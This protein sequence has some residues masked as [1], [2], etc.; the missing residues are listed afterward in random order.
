MSSLHSIYQ[1]L[2]SAN[3][4][5]QMQ[6]SPGAL[7]E[8]FV[9]P[10]ERNA[11]DI[12]QFLYMLS[13]QIRFFDLHNNPSGDWRPFLTHFV[14]QGIILSL[15]QLD[16]LESSR[17][18]WPPHAAL[19][20]SFLK[21]FS[22]AQADM[23]GITGKHLSYYYND[24]LGLPKKNIVPDKAHVIFTLSKSSS[25]T[26]LTSGTLLDA[27]KF[28]DGA[29]RQFSLDHDIVVN[30]AS[31]ES[32]LS[33]YTDTDKSGR[34]ILFVSSDA[35][36]IQPNQ[37]GSWRPFGTSQLKTSLERRNMDAALIGFAIASPAL[38]LSEGNRVITLTLSLPTNPV[39]PAQNLSSG[40]EIELT[41]PEEW[42]KPTVLNAQFTGN[43]KLIFTATIPESSP[44]VTPYDSAIHG[45]G[46][47][48]SWPVIRCRLKPQS[49]LLETLDPVSVT[50]VEVSVAVTG[51]KNLILQNDQSLQLPDK[52]IIPFTNQPYIGANFYIGSPEVF[53]KS[54]TSVSVH[55]TWQDPP[56]DMA[57]H[58]NGY[59]IAG[60]TNTTTF[61]TAISIL[62]SKNWNTRLLSGPQ[63][64]FNQATDTTR[65]IV[66]NSTSFNSATSTSGF[67]RRS[68]APDFNSYTNK[69]TQGFIKLELIGPSRAAF[70]N[71]PADAPFEAFGHKTFPS[72]Y[73]HQVIVVAQNNGVGDL[74]KP[75]YTPTL[76]SVSLDYTAKEIFYPSNPNYIDEYLIEDL[77]G[78]YHVNKN[79][80]A[81]VIPEIPGKGALYV[82]LK[83]ASAPLS[84][85]M[86]F[87][88]EEG[89]TPGDKLISADDY[90][91]SYLS[92]NGWVVIE[93]HQVLE[94]STK[95]LQAPGI[96]RLNLGEDAINNPTQVPTGMHWLRLVA[97][98]N[99]D[100]ASSILDLRAQAATA[101]LSVTENLSAQGSIPAN[102]IAGL[103]RKKSDIRKVEQPYSSFGGQPQEKLDMYSRRISERIRHRNR[104]VISWDFERIILDRFPEIFKVKCI[105]HSDTDT[106]IIPGA[107]RAVV[108]PDWKKRK[109]GDPLQPAANAALLREIEDVLIEEYAIPFATI[110]VTNPAY[111]TLLVDTKVAFHEEF[112]PG[113]YAQ[114]L[115]E[116]IK[117]FLS[118]W[119]YDEGQDIQFGGK[120]YRSEILAFVEG[121]EY[122][123]YVVD[124]NLYHRHSSGTIGGIGEMVIGIDFIIGV[125]PVPTVNQATI[126]LDFI[127][128][129]PVD[130][131]F[132]TRPDS[133][134][135]SNSYHR[136][137]VLQGQNICKG[138]VQTGIGQMI[139][140]IDFVPVS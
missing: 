129:E 73:A 21:I 46:Y 24:V 17:D 68:D 32:L 16:D 31:I 61:E 84:M 80:K 78:P 4:T 70:G 36:R 30:Q 27:G 117:R 105:P 128:G 101:T 38:L 15:P 76:K 74:P 60:M 12:L 9:R 135:V 5:N 97:K 119:A 138:V 90:S 140:G 122:V 77:F 25:P 13:S 51:M 137:N 93:P 107:V 53:H 95:E 37:T 7:A 6:R 64:L 82:G 81:R 18:D 94:D 49:Y 52:P 40:F 14:D 22:I 136:I 91:W 116:E 106:K 134:L 69:L 113:F 131:G 85:S 133:I 54:V 65:S 39:I 44:A 115:E 57:S 59:G 42:I 71:Q 50:S 96:I 43:N 58:Y 89:S 34:K 86:L 23:N 56:P 47:D 123:D 100:G 63:S 79:Q 66:V 28:T 103:I 45:T 3:G 26:L 112:D 83:N 110:S 139:I 114:Q 125:S 20:W 118:P 87:Q 19:L 62:A 92:Q 1:F 2:L 104:A 88:F 72:V 132:A 126:G 33:S 111:E 99:A 29:I 41:S 121:R 120:I 102:T 75:A 48:T 108:V 127:I 55:L 10:D 124:F 8:D 11:H 130:F 98:E 35:K 67:K 109:S